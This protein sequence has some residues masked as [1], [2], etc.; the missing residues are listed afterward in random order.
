MNESRSDPIDPDL[1]LM[2]ERI[3]NGVAERAWAA[4]TEPDHL[5]QW[6]APPPA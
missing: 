2:V 4:W 5:R 3:V 6:Y 1:D